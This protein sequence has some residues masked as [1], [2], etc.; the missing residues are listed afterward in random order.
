MVCLTQE[1][2]KKNA[3]FSFGEKQLHFT[4]LFLFCDIIVTRVREEKEEKRRS[5]S[6]RV[7]WS[8]DASAEKADWGERCVGFD[9][10]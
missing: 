9:R 1:K 4:D 10:E 7:F 5:L 6:R 8:E 2:E 3:V